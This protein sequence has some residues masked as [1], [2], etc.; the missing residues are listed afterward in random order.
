VD[1][2]EPISA[3]ASAVSKEGLKEAQGLLT[4]LLGPAADELGLILQEKARAYRLRNV[5][6]T[7]VEAGRRLAAVGVEPKPIP[8]RTLMPILEGSSLEEEPNLAGLWAGLLASAAMAHDQAHP[9]FAAILSQMSP[10]EARV[11]ELMATDE[12]QAWREF[13]QRVASQIQVAENE[14]NRDYGNLERLGLC[15]IAAKPGSSPGGEISISPFGLAFIAA[16]HGPHV[17]A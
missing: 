14:I 11:L 13:R 10:R 6:R 3:A 12:K 9:A 1:V 7:S 15:R 8:L 16:V 2:P 17:G 5:V 4:R